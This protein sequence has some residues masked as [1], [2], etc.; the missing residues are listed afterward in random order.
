MKP[1]LIFLNEKINKL[2]MYL[3]KRIKSISFCCEKIDL[4]GGEWL[5]GVEENKFNYLGK[6]SNFCDLNWLNNYGSVIDFAAILERDVESV[7]RNIGFDRYILKSTFQVYNFLDENKILNENDIILEKD[8][9]KL[10]YTWLDVESFLYSKEKIKI[11]AIVKSKA[12]E[13]GKKYFIIRPSKIYSA[14]DTYFDLRWIV[15]NFNQ[16]NS[17][18]FT[19]EQIEQN[20]V[21][22]PVY[23]KDVVE[24]TYE[25]LKYHG[26]SEIFNV[27][28]DEVLNLTQ[29]IEK[30]ASLLRTKYSIEIID[31]RDFD[32][33]S[34]SK[35]RVPVFQKKIV[36]S[37]RI[38]EK[39]DFEFSKFDSWIEEVLVDF[40]VKEA[41]EIYLENIFNLKRQY[42]IIK[43]R[44]TLRVIKNNVQG[45]F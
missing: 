4:V 40:S 21:A 13:L 27:S 30:I 6:R 29:M 35:Y 15:C 8:Y 18:L 25:L 33:E 7:I 1:I 39:L 20:N 22:N 12:E 14:D 45:G 9:N 24:V 5:K 38:K 44:K 19:K 36:N 26:E 37:L 28:Q 11:E 43:N 41:D 2:D 34:I 10:D 42:K 17:F 16:D 31:K 3:L 23:Y 32:E